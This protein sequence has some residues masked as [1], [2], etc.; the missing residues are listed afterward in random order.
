M[1][2]IY[3]LSLVLLS[4]NLF[5]Q[6]GKD[7][8]PTISAANTIV[9]AYTPLTSNVTSGSTTLNVGNS[10]AFAVGDL[11]YIIQ[12]QGANVNNYDGSFTGPWI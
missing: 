4:L 7:G 3:A 11:I 5:S 1:K 10:T 8:T 2:S 12:M 9:N 6:R